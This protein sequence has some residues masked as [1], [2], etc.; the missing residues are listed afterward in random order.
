M[1]H[2]RF[3]PEGFIGNFRHTVVLHC[4]DISMV[5]VIRQIGVREVNLE[6]TSSAER[7][8]TRSKRLGFS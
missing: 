5:D 6:M 2:I 8:S 4:Q 1:N 3:T 7:Y